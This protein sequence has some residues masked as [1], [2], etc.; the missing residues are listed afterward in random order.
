M[1][2]WCVC[3]WGGRYPGAPRPTHTPCRHPIEA[4]SEPGDM[5]GAPGGAPPTP[6]RARHTPRPRAAGRQRLDDRAA[7]RA[8]CLLIYAADVRLKR[9]VAFLQ[10]KRVALVEQLRACVCGEGGGGTPRP[11]S[12]SVH[13][14]AV[15]RPHNHIERGWF[16]D[17]VC[18]LA[19]AA[20]AAR[21]TAAWATAAACNMAACRPSTSLGIL[22]SRPVAGS[23]PVL[24]VAGS[25]ALCRSETAAAKIVR[26]PP[27]ADCSGQRPPSPSRRRSQICRV[28][29]A[30]PSAAR[31]APAR[32][33]QPP[34]AL[35]QAA[36]AAAAASERGPCVRMSTPCRLHAW[37][38]RRRRSVGGGGAASTAAR[39]LVLSLVLGALP[40]LPPGF[41]PLSFNGTTESF[42]APPVERTGSSDLQCPPPPPAHTSSDLQCPP[43]PDPH[44][45]RPPV[46]LPP[47]PDT[48]KPSTKISPD[49]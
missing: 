2:T 19:A 48:Y 7:L 9:L 43:P 40:L 49:E 23:R 11:L 10:R 22:L 15:P 8:A 38:T 24:P 36:P 29:C 26:R 44:K 12:R 42:I 14:R 28:P 1:P 25:R 6:H 21:P 5:L 41:R 16:W 31:A 33:P 27:S 3:V 45:L 30:A 17:R 46:P 47:R 32:R 20:A 13:R 4:C 39:M 35:A 37:D 34:A 18:M